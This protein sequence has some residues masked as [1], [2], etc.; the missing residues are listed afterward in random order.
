MPE[1]REAESSL[2]STGAVCSGVDTSHQWFA[3]Y[4]TPRHEKHVSEMLAERKIETFLP[5]YSIGQPGNGRRASRL[6]WN[7]PCSRP[8]FLSAL[9]GGRGAQSSACRGC[10]RL[11]VRREN[12]GLCRTLK[13]KHYVPVFSS[14]MSS[15][16]P[17]WLWAREYE[18]KPG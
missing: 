7:S 11:W 1:I 13:S 15:P 16:T 3:A 8:T 2:S 10:C 12:H 18:S 6:F 4:T 9:H 17:T 5:L 14:E